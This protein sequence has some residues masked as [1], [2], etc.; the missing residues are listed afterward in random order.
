M[1]SGD[2]V[3]YEFGVQVTDVSRRRFTRLSKKFV[4]WSPLNAASVRDS[5]LCIISRGVDRWV[6]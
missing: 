6:R 3:L 2:D 4:S 5:G 1:E